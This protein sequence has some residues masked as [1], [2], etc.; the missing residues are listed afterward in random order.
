MFI[1]LNTIKIVKKSNKISL[2]YQIKMLTDLNVLKK[3]SRDSI[4]IY[5]TPI[6]HLS[7]SLKSYLFSGEI[8]ICK[9]S[10]ANNS[11]NRK[12]FRAEFHIKEKWREPLRQ[13]FGK[14]RNGE[15]PTAEG[16]SNLDVTKI[17]NSVISEK[18]GQCS[19]C[20][21]EW[22]VGDETKE[23]P[24]THKFHPGCILPWLNKTNSCPMCRHELPTDDADYEE[25]KKQKRRAKERKADLEIL[26]NSMFS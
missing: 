3:Y 7:F 25:Y 16:A 21:K 11:A 13:S 5:M 24:C 6:R 8:Q 19:V 18:R 23:L 2:V 4:L 22:C 12:I 1:V 20:L 10:L 14:E 15:V 26:H 17:L 9:P